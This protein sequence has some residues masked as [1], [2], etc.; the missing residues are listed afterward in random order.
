MEE[1]QPAYKK[2]CSV[3][4]YMFQNSQPVWHLVHRLVGTEIYIVLNSFYSGGPCKGRVYDLL[5]QSLI[6]RNG[7]HA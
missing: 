7:F 3:F 5:K 6:S 1:F 4:L 2:L